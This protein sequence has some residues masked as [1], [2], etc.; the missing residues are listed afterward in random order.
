MAQF[1]IGSVTRA[2]GREQ[3]R[4]E[5]ACQPQS[6]DPRAASAS[7]DRSAAGDTW[8]NVS[9]RL[10]RIQLAQLLSPHGTVWQVTDPTPEAAKCLKSLHIKPPPP[11]LQIA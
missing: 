11:V 1:A 9:D 5:A 2:V 3:T 6:S 8:R 10:R 4:R 7:G